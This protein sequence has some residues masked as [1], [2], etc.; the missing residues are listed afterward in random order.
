MIGTLAFDTKPFNVDAVTRKG[1]ADLAEKPVISGL[2]PS[3]FMGDGGETLKLSGRL[4][5]TKIG[6]LSELEIAH[7]MRRSGARVPV[8]RGDGF[9]LGTFAIT[10]IEEKHSHLVKGGV[11]FVVDYSIDLKKVQDD[12]DGSSGVV[13]GLL[14]LFNSMGG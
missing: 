9:R 6:G 11:G 13:Q 14:S 8:S 5:P 4:L 3:E 1:T 10:A 12:R 2:A 7:Q